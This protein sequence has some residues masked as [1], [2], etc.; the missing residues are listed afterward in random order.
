[1]SPQVRQTIWC[2]V[3]LLGGLTTTAAGIS[4]GFA[5]DWDLFDPTSR[6]PGVRGGAGIVVPSLL[7]LGPAAVISAIVIIRLPADR[8]ASPRKDEK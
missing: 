4:F 3:I 2:C 1:M 8:I 5:V 6:V 7:L